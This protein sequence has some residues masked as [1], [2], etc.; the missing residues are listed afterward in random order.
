MR[1]SKEY[2][3]DC[4]RKWTKEG[5]QETERENRTKRQTYQ[6][7][8]QKRKEM[9]RLIICNYISKEGKSKRKKVQNKRMDG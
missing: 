6:I 9:K 8:Q 5:N 3:Q 4:Y 1:G 7:K 2:K